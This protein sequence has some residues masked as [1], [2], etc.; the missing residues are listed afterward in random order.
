MKYMKKISGESVY[1]SPLNPDD[2][3]IYTAWLNESDVMKNIG[4]G[5]YNNNII[6]C[7]EWF[8]NK[9]KNDRS[10]LYIIVKHDGDEPI[11]YFEFMEIEPVHRTAT[12]CVFIGDEANRGKGYGTQA[13]RLGVKFGFDVLNLNNIE[14]KVYAFNE[15]AI[16]SYKK[17]GFKEY[18]RRRQAY[19][20]NGEYHDVVCMDILR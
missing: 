3:E 14:L 15:R 16:S 8:E 1:L 9:L 10:A 7:K 4:G 17:V 5:L 13:V 19:Y 2:F 20:L 18:G 6:A 11:G 12:F